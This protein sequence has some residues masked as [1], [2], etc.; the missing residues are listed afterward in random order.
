VLGWAKSQKE[1]IENGKK[2]WI[3][4]A[5]AY[6][7]SL[8]RYRS[9]NV[10][11]YSSPKERTPKGQPFITPQDADAVDPFK[12][13]LQVSKEKL[14]HIYLDCGVGDQLISS[15]REF[16]QLLL[17]NN[18]P[19]Q[20]GQSEGEHEE[21]YWGRELSISMAVQYSI[22]LRNIWGRKFERYDAYE[23]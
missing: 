17:E 14:P 18:V 6:E 20:Y 7:D 11:G 21:D 16:M 22:M 3:I 15:T 2:P 8:T 23:N 4:W 9:I 19:F 10:E 12:L 5:Q 13:V 1:L